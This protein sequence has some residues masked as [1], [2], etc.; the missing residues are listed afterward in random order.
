MKIIIDAY[1]M[2]PQVTGTDRQAR[3]VLRELQLLDTAHE[4]EYVVIVN[5]KHR[6]VAEVVTAPN[7]KLMPLLIK[8]FV[9]WYLFG[10]PRLIRQERADVF[11]SFHNFTSPLVKNSKIVVSALDLIPFVYQQTYF[12]GSVNRW[13]RR[14]LVLGMMKASSLLGDAFLANSHFTRQSVADRFKISYNMIDVGDL[15]AESV[16]FEKHSSERVAAVRAKY[17]LPG[18][19]IFCLGGSEPR[20]NVLS[21]IKGHHLLPRELQS[22]YPVVVGG[23]KWQDTDFPFVD[24]PLVRHIGFVDDIDLPVVFS[25]AAVF[26]WPS[27]FEG[28][29]LPTLEAMASGTPVLT[30]MTTSLPEAVG[31]AAVKV[32]PKDIFQIRDGL[33]KIL[34]DSD[35]RTLLIKKGFENVARFSW[36]QNAVVLLSLFNRVLKNPLA[37]HQRG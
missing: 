13:V 18:S 17:Q 31:N 5:Q 37:G 4:H 12:M 10:L 30:S 9:L 6:F 21:V 20:K 27:E 36:K 25:L 8:R 16:F 14:P 24:D 1:Q 32:D 29:G 22:R 7:F 19:F 3:N 34:M 33:E 11:F 15:Q 23:A 26:A 28:F 35:F 2:A